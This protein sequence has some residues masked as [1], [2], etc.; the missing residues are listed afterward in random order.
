MTVTLET[1]IIEEIEPGME[2]LSFIHA[3]ESY[4][5]IM[6]APFMKERLSYILIPV[7]CGYHILPRVKLE[8]KGEVQ[9]EDS[10][11]FPSTVPDFSPYASVFINP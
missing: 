4:S 8:V 5:E 2:E 1:R 7:T 9:L 10:G 6:I 3:G 11:E